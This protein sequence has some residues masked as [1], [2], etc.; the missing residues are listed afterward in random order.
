MTSRRF[1]ERLRRVRQAHPI[2]APVILGSA[3]LNEEVPADARRRAPGVVFD[4]NPGPRRLPAPPGRAD[5]SFS[6][7]ALPVGSLPEVPGLL[8]LAGERELVFLT[9]DVVSHD[10]DENRGLVHDAVVVALELVVEPAQAERQVVDAG[11]GEVHLA[12][13][14]VGRRPAVDP[15]PHDDFLLA[16]RP[17]SADL[18][19]LLEVAHGAVD[20]PVVPAAEVID[21]HVELVVLLVHRE[22]PPVVVVVRVAD[23]IVVHVREHAG[24]ERVTHF[25]V[26]VVP[27]GPRFAGA[28]ITP[29]ARDVQ[30]QRL[31]HFALGEQPGRQDHVER[32]AL[33]ED[34][35]VGVRRVLRT[36]H[37][38][39]VGRLG[40]RGQE[41]IRAGEG[42]AVRSDLPARHRV[43]RRPLDG[44][45]A[46]LALAPALIAEPV[47]LAL[48]LVAAAFVLRHRDVAPGGEVLGG[49]TG[50]GA[51]VVGGAL[52][53][54]G[55]RPRTLPSGDVHIRRE[56]GAVP[57]R[58][59][60][61]LA[62]PVLG[63]GESR[64]QQ[65]TDGTRHQTAQT[66]H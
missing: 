53:H 17:R 47:V 35:P 55:E 13:A 29:V 3:G 25:A 40:R 9:P 12:D 24:G 62:G 61:L 54:Y 50:A 1:R 20:V 22:L 16:P 33:P 59:H 41:L 44:V 14:V 19:H 56:A 43:R 65:E 45:V 36:E 8:L 57:H 5:P 58:D 7:S 66:N 23:E 49:R 63:G 21:G 39:E 37:R 48:R 38:L 27:R 42:E 31:H 32:P 6:E 52:E 30:P 34:V 4:R 10:V 11:T 2:G 15:G 64:E 18:V 51:L 60:H 46:V 26:F 28:Q